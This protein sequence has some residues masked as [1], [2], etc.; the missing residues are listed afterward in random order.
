MP[1]PDYH[2]QCVDAGLCARGSLRANARVDLHGNPTQLN[3][4]T[5]K[6][7]FS[8]SGFWVM[9]SEQLSQ[10]LLFLYC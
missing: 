1:L 7:L 10:S 4:L 8:P 5:N 6:G 2:W 9:S 3:Y